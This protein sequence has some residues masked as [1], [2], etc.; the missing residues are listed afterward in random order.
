M[1][2]GFCHFDVSKRALIPKRKMN[3]WKGYDDLQT[4]VLSQK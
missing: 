4:S 2:H 1:P 3:V